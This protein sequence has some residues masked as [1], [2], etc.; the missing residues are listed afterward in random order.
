VKNNILTNKVL[1]RM[2]AIAKGEGDVQ[3][4]GVVT[5]AMSGAVN[6]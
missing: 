3:M 5:E 1:Q 4:D 6:Q 2:V